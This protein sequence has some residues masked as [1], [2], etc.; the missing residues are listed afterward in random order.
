MK[1]TKI[2]VQKEWHPVRRNNV[3]AATLD[4]VRHSEAS[5]C[6]FRDPGLSSRTSW[7]A[8]QGQ[9]EEGELERQRYSLVDQR[10]R[11]LKLRT[12]L[13]CLKKFLM[14]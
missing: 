10:Q 4:S 3:L 6:T 1:N 2:S 14:L 13:I 11:F 9:Q 12:L 5:R 8:E 7:N